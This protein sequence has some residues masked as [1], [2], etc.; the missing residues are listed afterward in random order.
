MIAGSTIRVISIH[1]YPQFMLHHVFIPNYEMLTCKLIKKLHVFF[2]SA[3]DRV[4]SVELITL[5]VFP[6]A[7]LHI[8]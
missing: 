3:T 5:D 6:S 8:L 7:F 2:I 1:Q 4:V